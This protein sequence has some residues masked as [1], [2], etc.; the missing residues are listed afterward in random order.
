M[1]MDTRSPARRTPSRPNPLDMSGIEEGLDAIP[2]I[3]V[4]DISLSGTSMNSEEV[5]GGGSISMMSPP[6]LSSTQHLSG[7]FG[8]FGSHGMQTPGGRAYRGLLVRLDRIYT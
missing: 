7:G 8:A 6:G 2:G 1:D 5:G 3:A 4:H